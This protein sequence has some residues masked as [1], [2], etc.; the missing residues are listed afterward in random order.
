MAVKHVTIYECDV[1]KWHVDSK[2]LTVV[3]IGTL[4]VDA[5]NKCLREVRNALGLDQPEAAEPLEPT[6]PHALI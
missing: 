5:C 6:P 4:S 1:C 2:E 3:K